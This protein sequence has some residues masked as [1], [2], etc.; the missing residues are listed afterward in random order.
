MAHGALT[1]AELQAILDDIPGDAVVMLSVARNT[2]ME[3][4][5]RT[6]GKR[7]STYRV[8]VWGNE[9]QTREIHNAYSCNDDRYDQNST[10]VIEVG[11]LGP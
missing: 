4:I 8:V 7:T 2:D 1:V 5:E 11:E 10:V 3:R 6:F 9:Y